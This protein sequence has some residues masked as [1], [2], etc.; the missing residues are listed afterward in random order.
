VREETGI[1]A[2]QYAPAF[3]DAAIPFDID[4]HYIPPNEKRGEPEHWHL[5]FRYAFRGVDDAVLTLALDEVAGAKWVPLLELGTY[6][7]LERVAG[8]LERF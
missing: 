6:P 5:D 1:T 4:S 2:V 3:V 8:K 7:T